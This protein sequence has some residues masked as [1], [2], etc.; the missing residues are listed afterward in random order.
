[1]YRAKESLLPI[2]YYNKLPKN[3]ICDVAYVVDPCIGIVVII[4]IIIIFISDILFKIV[5][6]IISL[7]LKLIFRIFYLWQK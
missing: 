7:K 4:I 3:I 5:I 2:Q 6:I 1:M